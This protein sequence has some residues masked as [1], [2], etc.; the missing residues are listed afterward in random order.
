[1][2][3]KIENGVLQPVGFTFNESDVIIPDTVTKIGKDAFDYCDSIKSVIIPESVT[4]IEEGAFSNCYNLQSVIFSEGLTKIGKDAF[5]NCEMIREIVIPKSVTEIGD[6]AFA[7]I[8][9]LDDNPA[10]E[11]IDIPDTVTYIGQRAFSGTTWLCNQKG[12]FTIAGDGVLI[13]YNGNDKIVN[14]PQGVKKISGMVFTDDTR[15]TDVIIPDSVVSI[16]EDCFF[17]CTSLKNIVIPKSVKFIGEAAFSETPWFE[18]CNK[19][20]LVVG[21]GIF[22]DYRGESPKIIIA[23]FVKRISACAFIYCS[24][25]KKVCIPETVDYIGKNAFEGCYS[26][27]SINIPKNVTKILEGTF[28]NCR[29]LKSIK[30]HE[31]IT[32][33]GENAFCNCNSLKSI[34]IPRNVKYIEEDS[35]AGCLLINKISVGGYDFDPSDVDC[36]FNNLHSVV[37]FINNDEY[38]LDFDSNLKY[39]IAVM[40]LQKECTPKIVKFFEDN[41][42]D[43]MFSLILDNNYE[44]IKAVFEF[45]TFITKYNI[46]DILQMAIYNTQK[47]G[48]ISIQIYI[49]GYRYEHFGDLEDFSELTL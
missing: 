22:L 6:T 18:N 43:I 29:L 23:D 17:G 39:K 9:V 13:D 35:F 25:I 19:K 15:I 34:D 27:Q 47:G 33:I 12:D 42:E 2:D 4:E 32:E 8:D 20:A 40:V 49:S 31:N 5:L 45:G 11:K 38:N 30:L 21:D 1:M 10:I 46:L 24:Q 48:D 41:L 3:F 7:Q 14:I 28:S 37:R 44:L 16:G 26:L 36:V